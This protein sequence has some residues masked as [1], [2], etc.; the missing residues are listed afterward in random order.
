MQTIKIAIVDD[1]QIIIDGLVAILGKY[2]T[3]AIVATANNAVDMLLLLETHAVDILLTDVMM[4]GM[5]GLELA[6]QVRQRYP[7]IKIIA[8]SMSG[9]VQTVSHMIED[10]DIAGYLLKQSS[11]DELA[12]AIKKVHAG[13]IYFQESILNDL[14]LLSHQ[15]KPAVPTHVTNREKQLIA[16]IEKNY[17]NKEIAAS[18]NISLLT[19]ETHRKNILR[20]TGAS[21]VLSLVKWAYENNILQKTEE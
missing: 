18:L 15:K 9:Q 2:E 6:K 7:Q 13:G 17:S 4:P 1:H 16:L 5:S 11:G 14:Q 19:V 12:M 20:K 8:L 3:L 21:N 10:A